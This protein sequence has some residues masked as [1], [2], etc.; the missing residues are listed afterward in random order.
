V[1]TILRSHGVIPGKDV[2]LE[3]L[4]RTLPSGPYELL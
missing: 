2:E 3:V 1:E 4:R